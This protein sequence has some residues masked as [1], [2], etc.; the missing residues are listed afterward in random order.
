MGLTRCS[1]NMVLTH[2]FR[3]AFIQVSM[4]DKL[5]A[6]AYNGLVTCPW[7]WVLGRS[8]HGSS[9]LFVG[10]P[11][12]IALRTA[13]M[14]ASNIYSWDSLISI[15][16]GHQPSSQILNRVPGN[17]WGVTAHDSS[18]GDETF[19]PQCHEGFLINVFW[20]PINV[21]RLCSSESWLH[22]GWRM[23]ILQNGIILLALNTS[24]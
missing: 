19:T 22:A 4:P 5:R 3:T 12:Y 6:L 21:V 15:Q 9:P 10:P 8:L 18:K 1:T 14:P 24:S 20:S 7:T 17:L 13:W 23:T 2:W 16:G 11:L